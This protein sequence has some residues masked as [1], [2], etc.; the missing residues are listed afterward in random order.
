MSLKK[1]FSTKSKKSQN[2]ALEKDSLSQNIT[3][4]TKEIEKLIMSWLK[5]ENW[6][7][8]DFEEFLRLVG[9]KTPVTL[10]LLDRNDNS[11]E[12]INANGVK[13][14]IG[15]R[16]SDGFDFC[17][18]IHVGDSHSQ[19]RYTVNTNR[20][21]GTTR[22]LVNLLSKALVLKEEGKELSSYYFNQSYLVTIK[23]DTTYTLQF[24]VSSTDKNH[25]FYDDIE[26]Y[27]LSLNHPIDLSEVY[28]KLT[29][30]LDL[31]PKAIS[32]IQKFSLCL[33][34]KI[35][36]EEIVR[37]KIL[38]SY[39]KSHEY[40]IT[41]G[42]ETFHILEDDSWNYY[43]PDG[44]IKYHA[45]TKKHVISIKNVENDLTNEALVKRFP[46]IRAS[47]AELQK[48]GRA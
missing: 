28:K 15:L 35:D 26:T 45:K 47:I 3:C 30:F 2:A 5:N 25:L 37:G 27:L 8:N 32:D 7:G 33:T 39:G 23:F 36:G 31:S 29:K 34:E 43:S 40:A 9:I 14:L 22:P 18:E 48:K 12:C 19:K 13:S 46:D 21:D 1:F 17:S 10:S 44:T 42:D 38:L 16:F 24:N 41:K 6:N 4:D 20:Q 11:F